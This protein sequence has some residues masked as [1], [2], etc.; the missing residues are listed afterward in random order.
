[1]SLRLYDTA[2]R[3]VRDFEP[4]V[5][6]KVGVYHCGLTVQG[7]PHIGHI[8]KEVVFDVLRRWLERSGHEVSV[9]ANVTDIDDKILARSGEAGTEWFALAYANERALHSAYDVLGCLPPTYE[10]RA[11]GHVPEMLELM[12]E[13][14]EAGHA[15][16]AADGSGDVYFDV[17]SWPAYGELSNQRIEDM[18][19]AADADPRGK[20]DPRDFALWKGHKPGEPET[21]SWATPYGRGRPGWHLECSAMVGKYLGAEFDIHGG[22]LDLRFP[23]HENELAQSRAAGRP[24]ARWWMHNAMLNLGG[25]KMSKSVGNTMLVSEVVKRVRPVELRY[26]LVA[27]HYRSVVEFSFEALEEAG[28]AYRRI[29]G[30]VRRAD[31]VLG[32]TEGRTG[33]A[34]AEFAE[35]MDD[36][37]SVPAALAALQ[38]VLREGNKLLAD[39][40]SDALR[41]TLLSV[42]SMLDVLGLDPLSTT[43]AATGRT[44]GLTEVVDRLVAVALQERAAARE[45]KDFAAADR[46]RDSLLGAGVVVE[47]TPAG[48]RWTLEE[49][50]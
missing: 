16:P 46:V 22:G 6:G 50:P 39:G 47:D 43:W 8:R 48:P 3:E 33:M 29:E 38:A 44:T 5:A 4:L 24:F 27:S 23:H 10:P 31:E 11:T 36:D 41:G 18:E 45:R 28:A 30:F 34:C 15:Y 20:R 14:V 35:A 7:A 13:L 42:R 19:G 12:G 26:Y 25:S 40:P 32:G 9:V 1:M 17:R 49:R 2:T 21:A 37:L